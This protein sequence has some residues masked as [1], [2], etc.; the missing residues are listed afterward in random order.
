MPPLIAGCGTEGRGDDAAGLLVAR[1]LRELGLPAA[2][3]SGEGL[4]LLES[5]TGAERVILVDAVRTGAEA[6]AVTVWDAHSGRL[7]REMFSVSTHAFGVAEAIEM[8]R[9][10]GRLPASLM[11]YGI[12]ATRFEAGEPPQQAVLEAVERVVR[13]IAEETMPCMNRA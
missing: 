4:S 6:G 13:M 10:L 2:E 12:E 7:K 8:G 9:A 5:W 11:V 1:R 3:H